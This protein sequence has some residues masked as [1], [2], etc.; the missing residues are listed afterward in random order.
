MGGHRGPLGPV[1]KVE[2]CRRHKWKNGNGSSDNAPS[3]P[4]E[5][6]KE[7]DVPCPWDAA[8]REIRRERAAPLPMTGPEI[9]DPVCCGSEQGFCNLAKQAG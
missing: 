5:R 1:I 3:D 4:V 2:V 6:V 8:T 7:G 9:Q